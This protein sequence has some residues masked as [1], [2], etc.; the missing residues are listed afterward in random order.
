MLKANSK[1][2]GYYYKQMLM[3]GFKCS[4]EPQSKI[5]R[6]LKIF[7]LRNQSSQLD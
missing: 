5:K 2:S 1:F 4:C 6:I 7:N 3:F